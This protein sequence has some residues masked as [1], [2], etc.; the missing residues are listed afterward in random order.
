MYLVK[1][2]TQLFSILSCH[3]LVF[4]AKSP[5]YSLAIENNLV[6]REGR[7]VPWEQG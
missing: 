5:E 2:N 6:P 1:K 4:H 7:E 3:T